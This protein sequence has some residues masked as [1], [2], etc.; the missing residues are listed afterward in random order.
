MDGYSRSGFA[1]YYFDYANPGVLG[2]SYNLLMQFEPFITYRRKLY[3]TARFG[4]GISY[5]TKVY[6]RETNPTNLAWST[7]I[8]FMGTI[9]L[10]MQYRIN[11]RLNLHLGGDYSH[12]SNGGIKQPNWG[13]NFPVLSFGIDYTMQDVNYWDRSVVFDTGGHYNKWF[14][15]IEPFATV[16]TIGIS[17][18]FE[19]IDRTKDDAEDRTEEHKT[20][21]Y[22]LAAYYNHSLSKRHVLCA[23]VELVNDGYVA[24]KKVIEGKDVDHKQA[25]LL[26]GHQVLIGKFAFSIKFGVYVYSPYKH[27][28]PLYQRYTL[29]YKFNERIYTG[30][31]IKAHRHMADVFDWRWGIILF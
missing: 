2:S 1:F 13:L 19:D 27:V 20:W 11:K 3:F 12:I 18:D 23:G 4:A 28:D 7:P 31:S 21:I 24:G 17:D 5:L 15:Q 22:G 30:V 14:V 25:N 9:T 16:K 29:T 8:S 26:L 6:D 10:N